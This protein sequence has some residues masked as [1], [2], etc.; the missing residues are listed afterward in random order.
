MSNTH[1]EKLNDI[2]NYFRA[3]KKDLLVQDWADGKSTE[4]EFAG[5]T[6][7]EVH[8]DIVERTKAYT[9]LLD[10]GGDE[11]IKVIDGVKK[12]IENAFD[13][14][15]DALDKA[16]ENFENEKPTVEVKQKEKNK[17]RRR[18]GYR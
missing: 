18:N 4:Y 2:V 14:E 17:S 11:I 9:V 13:D 3:N 5:I 10:D 6:F 12:T 7:I 8:Q 15:L 16:Y 1:E